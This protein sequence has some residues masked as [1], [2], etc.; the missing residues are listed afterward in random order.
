MQLLYLYSPLIA[1]YNNIEP[2]PV[3]SYV[4]FDINIKRDYMMQLVIITIEF[5]FLYVKH[6]YMTCNIPTCIVMC[7][8]KYI[9]CQLGR[10][11]IS[12]I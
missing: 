9:V 7:T 2:V 10:E 6:L 5:Y 12:R 1:S 8:R 11:N 3:I 4:W